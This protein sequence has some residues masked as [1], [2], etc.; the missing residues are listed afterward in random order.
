M[1]LLHRRRRARSWDAHLRRLRA[2][3]GATKEVRLHAREG[4]RDGQGAPRQNTLTAKSTISEQRSGRMAA[5]VLG[6]SCALTFSLRP[7]LLHG[8]GELL[9]SCGADAGDLL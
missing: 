5:P 2:A 4:G 8:F 6:V 9:S 7:A 3:Q 1:G